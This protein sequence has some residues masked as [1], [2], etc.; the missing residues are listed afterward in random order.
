MRKLGCK[1]WQLD[2]LG[3]AT[4]NAYWKTANVL[5][6]YISNTALEIK[7]GLIPIEAMWNK[8]H[9]ERMMRDKVIQ[10]GEKQL[11]FDFG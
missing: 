5:G 7:F 10:S 2:K 8:L 6:R 3:K 9:G 1:E 4:S 11:V